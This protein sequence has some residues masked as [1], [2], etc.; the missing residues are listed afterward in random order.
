MNKA[1]IVG[2]IMI[3]AGLILQFTFEND[4]IDLLVGFLGGGGIMLLFTG[5]FSRKS[6]TE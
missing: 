4:G 6:K 2:I 5:S 3:I 1:R